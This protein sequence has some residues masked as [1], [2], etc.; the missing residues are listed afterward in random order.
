MTGSNFVPN[1][2]PN[3]DHVALESPLLRFEGFNVSRFVEDLRV[4]TQC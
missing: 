3:D 2:G 4:A 1:F